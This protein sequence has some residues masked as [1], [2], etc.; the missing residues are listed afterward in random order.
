MTFSGS[1][2]DFSY[3][4][5]LKEFDAE[6]IG[7]NK[8][9]IPITEFGPLLFTLYITPLQ[10]V[11]ARH[12]LNSLFY[13]DDT[14]LCI[15]IDPANQAPS[16]TALQTC[17]EDVMRWNTQN[18][19]R[20]NAEKTEVILFTSRFTNT[21]NIEK[22]FFDNTVIELTEKVRHLGVILVK[23]L[24]LTYHIYETCRKATNAIR[25][26]GHT[27]KYLTNE[28]L[29]LLINALVIS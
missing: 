9:H 8:R 13:A 20:S 21:P 23:N 28:N 24:T 1:E 26:I 11:I 16:L 18:M 12:N 15:A 10:G 19:L 5:K 2:I 27:R 7:K 4:S 22:L 29:K 14:Q 25:S 6:Y 3:I 17:I